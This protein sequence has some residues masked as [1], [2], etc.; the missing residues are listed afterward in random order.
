[1]DECGEKNGACEHRCTDT[2]GSY[3]CSC[4]HGYALAA[5]ERSCIGNLGYVPTAIPAYVSSYRA[6]R[7]Y[8]V[9]MQYAKVEDKKLKSF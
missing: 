6:C 3:R 8:T 1:M 5:D 7:D 4:Y 2:V 9:Y